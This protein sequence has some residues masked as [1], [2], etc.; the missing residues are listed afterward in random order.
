MTINLSLRFPKTENYNSFKLKKTWFFWPIRTLWLSVLIKHSF[1]LPLALSWGPSDFVE[2]KNWNRDLN[3]KWKKS[4]RWTLLWTGYFWISWSLIDRVFWTFTPYFRLIMSFYFE[5]N[6][7]NSRV[8]QFNFVCSKT[9]CFVKKRSFLN[10]H[11]LSSMKKCFY[12]QFFLTNFI[13]K[14]S[15]I[16]KL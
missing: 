5:K 11:N 1:F 16:Y 13:K 15:F 2:R 6:L 4:L 12:Y 10:F 9:L 3:A 7:K 8:F 14:L